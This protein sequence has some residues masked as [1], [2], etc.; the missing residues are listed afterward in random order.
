MTG[1]VP[2]V[3]DE[4]GA[5]GLGEVVRRGKGGKELAMTIP[6]GDRSPCVCKPGG[7]ETM[8]LRWDG[9]QWKLA[10]DDGGALGP[11]CGCLLG[12]RRDPPLPGPRG[13][14]VQAQP[15]P[16]GGTLHNAKLHIE[17]QTI[18]LPIPGPPL[19]TP[20]LISDSPT[21]PFRN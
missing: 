5:N 18:P 11:G 21:P 16:G 12:A 4:L 2:R 10:W 19:P 9:S 3:R 8:V 13:V 6:S 20:S 1:A 7:S 17:P 14:Q 15:P